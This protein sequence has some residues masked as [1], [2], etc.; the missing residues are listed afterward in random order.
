MRV[1][2][3]AAP[4]GPA[5]YQA[6]LKAQVASLPSGASSFRI[7]P[8]KLGTDQ[9]A[10][11]MVGALQM[12]FTGGDPKA[13]LRFYVFTTSGAAIT[14]SNAHLALPPKV[15][16]LLA[17]PPMA[18]CA[19]G[20]G[21]GYCEMVVQDEAVVMS[22]VGSSVSGTAAPLM[23]I[24]F[25]LLSAIWTSPQQ[26]PAR[27]APTANATGACALLSQADVEGALGGPTAGP[28]LNQVGDCYW[29]SARV[30]ADS[31]AVQPRNGGRAT[32]D[33]DRRRLQK[34]AALPG[35]GDDA[36]TFVSLAGF[37]QIGILRNGRYVILIFQHQGGPAALAAAQTLARKIAARL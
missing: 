31:V 15:G 27:P 20:Q 19:D 22:A 23:G 8:A 11:G 34:S 4:S 9:T 18:Q 1:A 35:V 25:R 28:R 21:A 5:L 13:E 3:H 29:D 7:T 16:T 14:Y 30:P 26:A 32:F 6:L 12:A 37:V 33:N 10:A 2:A 24:G 17:Y 36:Y